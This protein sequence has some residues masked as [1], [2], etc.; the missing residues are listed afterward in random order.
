MMPTDTARDFKMLNPKVLSPV[1]D[2]I[3]S[4]KSHNMQN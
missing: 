1:Q 3:S 2:L 4:E